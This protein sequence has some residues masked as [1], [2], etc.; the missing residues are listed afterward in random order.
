MFSTAP[1]RRAR[2]WLGLG[3]GF[4]FGLGLGLGRAAEARAHL[5][6]LLRLAPVERDALGVLAEAYERVAQVGLAQQLLGV[7]ADERAAEP[8]RGEGAEGGVRE[9]DVE[10]LR[11]D[12]VEELDG[13]D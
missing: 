2:T 11:V 6:R 12:G 1:P 9:D 3:F 4:G 7:L 5:L 10:E 8:E 13:L